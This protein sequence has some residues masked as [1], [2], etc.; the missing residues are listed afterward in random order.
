MLWF[1]LSL[2]KPLLVDSVLLLMLLS[3]LLRSKFKMLLRVTVSGAR[4][5]YHDPRR[6]QTMILQA[7][8]M[9]LVVS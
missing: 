9:S 1:A 2:L 5:T 6:S 3:L 4:A 7:A 8:R